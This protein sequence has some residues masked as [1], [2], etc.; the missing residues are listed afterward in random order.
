MT[1][2]EMPR[3]DPAAANAV[4][5][6]DGHPVPVAE[7]VDA[8]Q[9]TRRELDALKRERML[10]TWKLWT[11][12]Q[13]RLWQVELLKLQ[14]HLEQQRMRMIVLFEGRDAAGKGGKIRPGARYMNEKD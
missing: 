11:A 2:V 10:V 1:L 13:L 5:V 12:S 6:L 14:M 9:R 7:L 3:S 8:F 4:V